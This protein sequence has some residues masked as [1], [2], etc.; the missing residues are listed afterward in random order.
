M[1]GRQKG[2][3]AMKRPGKPVAAPPEVDPHAPTVPRSFIV[4]TGSVSK[5]AQQLIVDLRRVMEPNTASRL[6]ERKRNK[7][8]DFVTAA[9]PMG[10]SHI[11]LLSQG[12]SDTKLRMGRMPQGPTLYFDVRSF[13]LMH[14]V[15]ALQKKPR[16]TGSDYLAAP[17][18]V[19]N[20][21]P[22]ETAHGKLL[23]SMLQNMFPTI[24]TAKVKLADIRRVV[25][26]HYDREQ[27][28]VEFR[29]YAITI[30]AVGVSKSVKRIIRS[31]IRDLSKFADAA[32]F[33][34]KTE[35][36][37]SDSEME[38]DSIVTIHEEAER[39]RPSAAGPPQ[40]HGAKKTEQKSVNLVELGPR[41][42]LCLTKATDG[43]DN[44]RVLYHVSPTQTEGELEAGKAG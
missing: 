4:K 37:L 40:P 43:L 42:S 15:V 24:N 30:K 11:M 9:G 14:K 35:A 28:T 5:L 20:N 21:M 7:L 44:G 25:L 29:H 26:F 8:K 2:A 3:P 36:N 38:P 27:D 6:Q 18:L 41:M 34:L 33:V 17:L 19:L 39:Q 1:A 10:V 32:D 23:C 12:G 22:V 31:E 13:S 16:T